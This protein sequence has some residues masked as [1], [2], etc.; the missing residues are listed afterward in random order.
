MINREGDF[1]TSPDP[2]SIELRSVLHVRFQLPLHQILS[3]AF[4]IT[5]NFPQRKSHIST[6]KDIR[7]GQRIAVNIEQDSSLGVQCNHPHTSM[8]CLS[9]PDKNRVDLR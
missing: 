7:I 6:N 2:L 1:P 5:A 4:P 8:L 3:S 9:L